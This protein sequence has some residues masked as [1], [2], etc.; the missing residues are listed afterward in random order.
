MQHFL[1]PNLPLPLQN[2]NRDFYKLY[3]VKTKKAQDR[4]LKQVQKK[5]KLCQ[6]MK[7]KEFVLTEK[8]LY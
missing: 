5:V 3:E 6:Y 2:L 1:Y 8:C 4:F 7:I